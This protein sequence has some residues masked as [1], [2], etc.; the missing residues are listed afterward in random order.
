MTFVCFVKESGSEH[1]SDP[2]SN[3]PDVNPMMQ[4]ESF[5]DSESEPVRMYMIIIHVTHMLY[6][7]QTGN[8]IVFS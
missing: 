1:M 8:H 4:S 2:V 5:L 7:L 3:R 6:K